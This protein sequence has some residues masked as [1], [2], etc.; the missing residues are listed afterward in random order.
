MQDTRRRRLASRM[1]WIGRILASLAASW[2]IA[3][4]IGEAAS[5]DPGPFTWEGA[6][7]VAVGLVAIVGAVLSWVR[8]RSASIMLL[9]TSVLFGIHIAI[10]AGSHHLL[11]WLAV[12]LPY[13]VAGLLLLGS[14]RLSRSES[15]D[16]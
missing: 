6:T 7:V 14:L 12:G 8:Q 11:A 5:C 10:Y 1:G 15:T 13:F 2:W 9:V 16:S 4:F 3:V